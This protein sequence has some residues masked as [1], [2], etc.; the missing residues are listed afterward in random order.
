MIKYYFTILMSLAFALST[1]GQV[2]DSSQ[3]RYKN[4]ADNLLSRNVGLLFGGY[5]EAHYN[6]P[7][8]NGTFN[9]GTL[10]VHRIVMLFGYNFN[11]RTQFV[12]EIE[13]EHVKEVY[14]EQAFL[15][16]KVNNFLNLRGGLMLVPMG[17]INEYHEPVTFNGVER[18]LVDKYIAPTTWRELGVG[19]T[20]NVLPLSIK[21]QAYVVNGFNSFDGQANVSGKNGFRKG[22]QKGGESFMSALN[23]AGKVE[24]YG[25]RGLNLGV[26][27]YVGKTQSTLYNGI[28]KEDEFAVAT[29]DSSVLHMAM[30]G[31]DFRYSYSGF[32]LR[33]QFYY[34]NIGNSSQYNSFT[35]TEDGKHNDVGRAMIGYYAEIGYN[36]LRFSKSKKQLVPFVRYE[37]LDRHHMVNADTQRNYAYQV[38]NM[39]T[40]LSLHLTKGTVVKADIQFLKDGEDEAFSHVFNA[41]IGVWF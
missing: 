10:D 38:T 26:S 30:L 40:G 37:Y 25:I 19:F 24:Y 28:S 4:S 7:I 12:T 27:G 21:Y 34:T 5:G 18:P 17:I 9:N 13:F 29:A 41:G 31:M 3:S 1:V 2:S 20:G 6:Q 36:V 39:T 35:I 11:N 23:F 14:V 32:Q 8:N 15:Q 16:Y 22:R 33:G